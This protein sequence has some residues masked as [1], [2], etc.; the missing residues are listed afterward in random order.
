MAMRPGSKFLFIVYPDVKVGRD[1]GGRTALLRWARPKIESL[2][3]LRLKAGRPTK[4][5]F[6]I[7][8]FGT[9]N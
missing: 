3:P 8:L 7:C 5:G 2:M 4:Y 6:N 1:S 9:Y